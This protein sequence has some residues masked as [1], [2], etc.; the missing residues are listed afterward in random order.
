MASPRFVCLILALVTV[1]LY[2]PARHHGFLVFDDDLYVSENRFVQDGITVEGFRWAFTT[3]ETGNWHPLTWLSL[4]LD[5]QLFGPDAGTIHFVNVLLHTAN[6]VLLL[7]LLLR[8]TGALWPS[9][10]VAAL[11]AWHPLHVESVAW[12][13]ERKD[14][15]S[16]LFAL[17]SLLCYSRFAQART[18]EH[19]SKRL[20]YCLALLFFAL[21]LMAKPMLVTLPCV[22]LLLDWWPLGR[23]TICDLRL[24]IRQ[25]V[26]EKLPFFAL[27]VVSCVVTYQAQRVEAVV[28]LDRHPME[29]RLANAVVSYTAYLLKTV[30]PADLAIIYPLPTAIAW[31]HVV[32]AAVVL[33]A[34]SWFV[35]RQRRH[36]PCWPVG[37]LWYLGTLVPVIGLVQV[38]GQSMA[39]RYTYWPLI[40]VFIA[41]AFGA[42]AFLKTNPSLRNAAVAVSVLL[43]VA[44][45]AA[46][47][48]QLRYWRDS[49]TLF[50]RTVAVTGDN[51]VAR[52]NLGV[53]LEQTGRKE[54][55]LTNYKEALRLDPG[56]VQVHNN[57]ANLLDEL[58]K[59][60]E[61][62]AH[63]REALRLKPSAVV[64]HLNYGAFLVR[65]WRFAE[66][67]LHYTEASRLAPRDPRPFYL[68]ARAKLVQNDPVAAEVFFRDAL[69]VDAYD[70][71]TLTALSRL[72]SSD[73]HASVRNASDSITLAERANAVSGGTVPFVL[74]TLAMAYAAGGRTT[75]AQQVLQRA[76][77]IAEA[78]GDRQSASSLRQRLGEKRQP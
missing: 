45:L 56:R 11:F 63:Y 25:L 49:E 1:L 10:L 18:A 46:T 74:E 34:I 21:G 6:A 22:M 4:M 78:T 60:D 32:I 3:F 35:W 15:L 27:T 20:H 71:Q 44:C 54:D 30:W 68:M 28:A 19:G 47:A 38:G 23:F 41:V 77:V 37:W 65:Q 52:I 33:A 12:I 14:T 73:E 62:D 13:S 39:D 31:A 42:A 26:R 57:L 48:N 53:A 70:V 24:K 72:L 9:A 50:A 43:I 8:L 75:D 5:C 55:A 16:T 64:A 61:A 40:G 51:P 36:N 66:A 59:T 67:E 17:L 2:L 7:L 76:I 29:L 58:G 69:R